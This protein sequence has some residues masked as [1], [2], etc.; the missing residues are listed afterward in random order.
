M[1]RDLITY[2]L[3]PDWGQ[4]RHPPRFAPQRRYLLQRCRLDWK[5]WK[6]LQAVRN[7]GVPLR[8]VLK[9]YALCCAASRCIGYVS[10]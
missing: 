9:H 6:R 8:W 1:S 3:L 4:K 10:C 5:Y 2:Y 7:T